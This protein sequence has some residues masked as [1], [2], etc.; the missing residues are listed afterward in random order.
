MGKKKQNASTPTEPIT[1]AQ[2]AE[3]YLK[4]MEADGK[5]IGTCFSYAMEL[6][7]AQAELG[8]DTIVGTLTADDIARFNASDRVMKLKSGKPKA[9]P[10]FLKTQRVLRLALAFAEQTGLIAASP[11]PAKVQKS[12]EPAPEPEPT[13]A[14]KTTRKS[15]VVVEVVNEPQAEPVPAA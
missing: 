13:P 9:E 2:L 14:P 10:S 5:S 3:Q 15:R 6:K 8:A 4:H 7:T 1:L 12:D 11:I